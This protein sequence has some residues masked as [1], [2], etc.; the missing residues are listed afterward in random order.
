MVAL[1]FIQSVVYSI[2]NHFINQELV[3]S[4]VIAVIAVVSILSVYEFFVYHTVLRKSLYNKAFNISI[5]ILPYFI[6]TIIL[7]LQSNIVITLG[8][9]G[10]LAIVRFRTA[11]KDPVDMIFILWSIHI[12]IT[13]GCQ[14]YSVAILTSIV[15]TVILVL[16]NYISVGSKSHI[17]VVH[18]DADAEDK[19]IE[20]IKAYTLRYRIK[21]RN[22]TKAGVDYVV[23]LVTKDAKNLSL[24]LAGSE[25]VDKFSLMEYDTDDII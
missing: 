24:Q 15:V 22:Y 14:L 4:T 6:A 25:I 2:M 21:S 18:S 16:L 3:L 13:C 5:A 19:I 8:T 11:V 7:C 9:I 20:L 23:E 10:A 12:G 17:L 1:N